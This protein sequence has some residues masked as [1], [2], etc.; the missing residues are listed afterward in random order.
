[1]IEQVPARREG[2]R[3]RIRRLELVKPLQPALAGRGITEGDVPKSILGREGTYRRSLA[4]ADMVAAL[5][6]LSAVAV[7]G[8]PRRATYLLA[9]VPLIVLVH[10][11]GGLYDRDELVL[12]KTTLDEAPALLQ[13]SGIFTLLV[14]MGHAAVAR[15]GLDPSSVLILWV[16]LLGLVLAGR[17]LARR[18]A[19]V[20]SGPERCLVIGT[21][22]SAETLAS[23]L[24]SS[25]VRAN[26]VAHIP[27]DARSGVSS[28]KSNEL[29][30]LV[31]R[32]DVHRVVIAPLQSDAGDTLELI[33]VAKSVGV[34]VSVLPRMLE[35]VGSSVAFDH[36]EGLTMLGVRSFGLSRSSRFLKR[37]FDLV[38]A[39][40][41]LVAMAPVMI[42]VAIAI[43]LDSR[44]PVLFRQTRIGR[45]GEPF[46]ILK[47]RSMVV[48][49][50]ERKA[51]LRHLNDTEG[52]FKIKQD[53][54]VTRVGR[55]IRA[56]CLDEL[57]QLFNVLRGEMSLVG[58]RPLVVDEDAKVAGLDRAR[59]HLTPGMTGHWQILGS[60]RVPLNEMVGIDYLY[61]ANW[62]LWTDIKI[63]LRTARYVL[64]RGGV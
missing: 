22:E 30:D 58:P 36:I 1:M 23:K 9:F 16:M 61:V 26:I 33:R 18:W 15:W 52:L 29:R 62:S 38:G 39:S 59:L 46:Q 32:H 10:K 64:H 11:I 48:D 4:V 44:G 50:E 56:T 53:P 24:D 57:P 40:L 5:A 6:A 19:S 14:W 20:V 35:V 3:R 54:R 21:P 60:A 45:D 2:S 51:E 47:F 43:R 63:L 12:N 49:A 17:T 25:H 27:L 13:I 34:R 37:A 28:V 55:F 8:D 31:R 7:I 41:M 42:A